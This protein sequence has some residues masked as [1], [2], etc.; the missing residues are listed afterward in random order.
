MVAALSE[1]TS[2][3]F[4]LPRL[5]RLMLAHPTGRRILR[6]RPRL[7]SSTLSLSHLQSLPPHTLG[8]TYAAWLA[9]EHVTPDTRS[10]V[11]YVDDPELAYVLQRYRECHDFFHAIT[12]LPVW[13]E[14]ELAVKAF[15]VANLGLPMAGLA[16][17]AVAR[18]KPEQRRRFWGVY[19]PWGWRNGVGA[20]CMLNV[21]W[22]EEME[23][24]VGELRRRL[25]IEQPPDLREW[26]KRERDEKRREREAARE[27][28]DS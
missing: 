21:Y 6:T 11:R 2:T 16:L 27:M 24:D 4:P 20:E 1:V 18:M 23:T 10:P 17:G 7:N 9:R 12:G 22:E 26:R 19:G 8:A 13:V 5:R 15:E 3:P 28:A 25:G 14:G